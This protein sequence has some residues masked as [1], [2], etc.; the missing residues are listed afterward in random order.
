ML[1][2]AESLSDA[3]LLAIFLRTGTY[4]KTAIDLA[5]DLLNHYGGLRALL[6]IPAEQLCQHT[7]FGSAKYVQIH[8]ALEIG[9]RYLSYTMQKGSVLLNS[10]NT[11]QFLLAQLRH[12]T[13][14]V[15]AC[16]FVDINHHSLKFKILFNGTFNQATVYPREIAREALKCNAAA[17]ILTHNHPSGVAEPSTADQ[18]ITEKIIH[19]LRLVDV[20]VLDH[21]IVGDTDT[22]SFAE[23]GLL[24]Y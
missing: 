17:V 10:S 4:G 14:E 16:L 1:Q 18:E 11:R 15:F 6:D 9:R 2:G 3:E 19:C 22:F 23:H 20:Q 12:Y 7:G 21:I 13:H 5:R 8:A 24:F